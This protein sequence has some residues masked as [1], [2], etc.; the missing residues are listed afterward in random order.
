MHMMVG[1]Q[2]KQPPGQA[3]NGDPLEA[4]TGPNHSSAYGTECH[5]NVTLSSTLL[6]CTQSAPPPSRFMSAK[7]AARLAAL[8]GETE[9][10]RYQRAFYDGELAKLQNLPGFKQVW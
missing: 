3:L 6:P 1:S 8:R 9:A 7:T 2:C 4:E 10:L 5:M